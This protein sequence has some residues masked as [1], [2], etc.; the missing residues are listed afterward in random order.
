MPAKVRAALPQLNPLRRKTPPLE[1]MGVKAAAWGLTLALDLADYRAGR[2]AWEDVDRGCVVHGPPGTGKTTF[3]RAVAI[4]CDV[5]LIVTSYGD[6]QKA[7]DGHL[8]DVHKALS[9]VFEQARNSAPVILFIDEID[10]LPPR[11]SK[12]QH[13]E[14]Y[15]TIT[16]LLL[17][18]LDGANPRGRS[19]RS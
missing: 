15:H 18:E 4:K 1:Q 3:A 6:W 17:A 7:G 9:A 16:N 19:R 13:T 5:E 11:G 14:W 10:S 2:L 12:S 8:G